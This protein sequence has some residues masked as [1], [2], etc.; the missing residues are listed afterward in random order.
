M[1]RFMEN[2][3]EGGGGVRV[4]EGRGFMVT[5]IHNNEELEKLTFKI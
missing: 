2:F 4:E 1:C 5:P 3:A